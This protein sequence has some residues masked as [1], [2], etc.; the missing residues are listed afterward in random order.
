MSRA[1]TRAW[2]R[3]AGLRVVAAAALVCACGDLQRARRPDPAPRAQAAA[4][5]DPAANLDLTGPQARAAMDQGYAAIQREDWAAA[6][7]A[8]RRAHALEPDAAAPLLDL[9]IA[10]TELGRTDEAL[11][12]LARALRLAPAHTRAVNPMWRR[13][14]IARAN[15]LLQAGDRAA[16]R[17]LLEPL[18]QAHPEL[19]DAWYALGRVFLAY[20]R[21]GMAAGAFWSALDADPEDDD[22]LRGL[23]AALA[24]APD[25]PEFAEAARRAEARLADDPDVLTA[26]GSALESRGRVGEARDLYERALARAPGHPSASLNLARIIHEADGLKAA[27]PYY[28]AFVRGALPWQKGTVDE[29][30]EILES[31]P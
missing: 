19:G 15:A 25:S 4:K 3:A 2:A 9:G 12:A 20:G 29:V 27:R 13:V 30:R 10:L 24:N 23:V 7:Q 6:E 28:E 26:F 31:T 11:E 18:T 17:A 5:D 1:P 16:A 21:P 8:F 14:D 22:A